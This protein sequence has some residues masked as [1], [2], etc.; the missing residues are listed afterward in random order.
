MAADLARKFCG[1]LLHFIFK[2]DHVQFY[3]HSVIEQN[4]TSQA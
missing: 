3:E 1:F 2:I 4:V